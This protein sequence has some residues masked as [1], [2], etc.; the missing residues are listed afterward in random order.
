M[1]RYARI[2]RD[3]TN[4]NCPPHVRASD[5]ERRFN[6]TAFLRYIVSV[7][8]DLTHVRP[9]SGSLSRLSVSLSLM[10]A[11]PL[12]AHVSS[13]FPRCTRA[14]IFRQRE[15]A[16]RLARLPRQLLLSRMYEMARS[17]PDAA[18]PP[19]SF[20]DVKKIQILVLRCLQISFG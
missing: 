14:R 2:E 5:V 7:S 10:R 3:W 18:T 15:C 11:P 19:R 20:S 6:A 16:C 4:R 1:L 12:P 17:Q 13:S 9:I 8:S